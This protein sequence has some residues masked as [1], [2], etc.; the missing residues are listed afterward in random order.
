[1]KKEIQLSVKWAISKLIQRLLLGQRLFISFFLFDLYL[2]SIQV[3]ESTSICC[4]TV[5]VQSLGP[6]KNWKNYFDSFVDHGFNA[7]HFTPPQQLGISKSAYCIYDQLKLSDNLF[8]EP[9]L[10]EEVKVKKFKEI[11]E[12]LENNNNLFLI[13][14]VVWNHTARNTPWLS[15]QLDSTYNVENSPYLRPSLTVDQALQQFSLEIAEGKHLDKN[16]SP[17]IKSE[18]DLERIM[19][20]IQNTL[21]PSLRLW[22][23][24][25][26]DV[27]DEVKKFKE[28]VLKT[29]DLPPQSTIYHG[30]E[31]EALKREGMYREKGWGRYSLRVDIVWAIKLFGPRK[32]PKTLNRNRIM[33][34]ISDYKDALMKIN[35]PIYEK[36]NDDISALLINVENRIRYERLDPNGP[37]FGRITKDSPLVQPYFSKI[38]SSKGEEIYCLNNGW[39]WRGNPLKNFADYPASS[40]L[41]REVIIWSDL[42]KL[43]YGKRYQDNPWLWDHMKK[44]SEI[45]AKL[46]HGF[47]IDNCHS[48]PI[49]VARFLIDAARKVRPNLYIVAELFTGN[50]RVDNLYVSKLGINSLIRESMQAHNPEELARVC[51]RYGRQPV[52]SI[53]PYF[54]PSFSDDTSRLKINVVPHAPPAFIYDCTHDNPTPFQKRT[55]E[56]S[57]PNAAITWMTNLPVGTTE[58]YDIL[59]DKNPEVTEHRHYKVFNKEEVGIV[60]ARKFLNQLH[61]RLANEGYHELDV[62]AYDEV[63]TINRHNPTTHHSIFCIAFTSFIHEKEPISCKIS[64]PGE[65]SKILFCASLVPNPDSKSPI[66]DDKYIVGTDY[67]KLK[68]FTKEEQD[69]LFKMKELVTVKEDTIT[70]IQFNKVNRGTVLIFEVDL[71]KPCR[72][73]IKDIS[74]IMSDTSLQSCFEKLS[75]SDFT[76]LLYYC[77]NEERDTN[78]TGVYDVPGYGPLPYAGICG[79]IP[80]LNE[81]RAKNDMN[82]PFFYN[83]RDGNWAI[84]FILRRFKLNKKFEDL[85]NWLHKYLSRVKKL[86]RN[87]IPKYFDIVL[88]KVYLS[89]KHYILEKYMNSTIRNHG[90]DFLRDLAITSFQFIAEIKSSPLISDKV[91]PSPVSLSFAAGLPHFSTGY[92]RSWGRDTFISLR[93]L[94]LLTGRYDDA[95]TLILGYASVLRHGLIP[96]LIDSGINPRYNA[97]DAT[98]WFLYSIQEY[99]RLS[100]QG[101]DILSEK[102]VKL[103]PTDDTVPNLHN[104]EECKLSDIIQEIMQRHASGIQFRERNAGISLDEF[105]T[106]EG[107]NVEITL[108]P[109]TGF[110]YGGNQWNCGTWMD[111]MGSSSNAGNKGIPATPRD[112]AAI[113]I[114][115]LLKSTVSW[116]SEISKKYPKYF[117]H[118]GVKVYEEHQIVDYSYEKWSERIKMNFEKHFYVPLSIDKDPDY[119]IQKNIVHR[120]GIYKDSYGSTHKWTDYQL[121]PNLCIAM[122]VAPELFSESKAI[123]VMNLV[124]K[125]LLGP[126]GLKT[127][128]HHDK[129]YR[130]YYDSGNWSNDY[131]VANG[132]NYHLGPEWLWLMGYFIRARIIFCDSNSKIEVVNR[133]QRILREHRNH[134]YKSHWNGLPELTNYKGE[135]C[136]SSCK[137]QAWSHAAIIEALCDIEVYHQMNI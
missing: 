112:G 78:G 105:M 102:V 129:Q 58:G 48:T 75:K 101:I 122:V 54:S 15:E 10:S 16:I 11:L 55:L 34:S 46:F 119:I 89:S 117:P 109:K 90:D 132:F 53:T 19:S 43:R 5:L 126:L 60:K 135:E 114:I 113:E 20:Y 22:E 66:F 137:S 81:I 42:V 23:F 27:D 24:F 77:E 6:L 69:K 50:E 116:L 44:Y 33:E 98:W 21:I 115:A 38:I 87:L 133:M 12:Y 74:E 49:R 39:V 37:K 80:I 93:G 25:V 56:D 17:D 124:E 63:I 59:I 91:S 41:R 36:L 110:I 103:F 51:E 7:V 70:E 30:G 97:R 9:N 29:T 85:Y 123:R 99:C 61:Q 130:P 2:T 8:E 67:V 31:I 73:A 13:T 64:I 76:Y 40:Y 111:K 3:L 62:Y 96:N 57:L 88:M 72:E 82:H 18:A 45:T 136:Y 28:E 32:S 95:R 14:D 131:F 107:F 134:F 84:D 35:L 79:F 128:D 65:V 94:C 106:N 120:R 52:G 108:D 118:T 127:L 86:P 121:R 26:V 100:P 83:L 1:M 4:K 92:M 125:V 68:M 104:Y 47:R 71:P